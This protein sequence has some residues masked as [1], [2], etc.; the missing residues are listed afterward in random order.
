MGGQYR[1]GLCPRRYSL[2]LPPVLS[3]VPQLLMA[4]LGVAMVAALVGGG[5]IATPAG[6]PL[7]SQKRP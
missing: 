2:I 1:L 5:M 3:R 4:P 7:D 6:W